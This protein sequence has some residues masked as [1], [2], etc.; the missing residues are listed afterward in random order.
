MALGTVSMARQAHGF[1]YNR[2]WPDSENF[3]HLPDGWKHLGTGATRHALLAPDGVVYKVCYD[4][5]DMGIDINETEVR[6]AKRWRRFARLAEQNIFVPK[7]RLIRV[8]DDKS[9]GTV[10]AM[11][12]IDGQPTRCSKWSWKPES[13]CNCRNCGTP[14]I[15]F[16]VLHEMLGGWGMY[17]MFAANA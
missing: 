17:D 9:Y 1:V 6:V 5:C 12:F 3:Y 8:N 13:S 16:S 4:D 10:T 11:E 14:R 7:M 2:D 15:C